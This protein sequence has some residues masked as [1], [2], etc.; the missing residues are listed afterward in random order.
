MI[1]TFSVQ[2]DEL[3][4]RHP[5]GQQER[6]KG[7]ALDSLVRLIAHRFPQTS[8]YRL[9]QHVVGAVHDRLAG[10]MGVFHHLH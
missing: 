9:L 4:V 1:Q 3:D 5:E 2:R 7:Q 6:L 8:K 10:C